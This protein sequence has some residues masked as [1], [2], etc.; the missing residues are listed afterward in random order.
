MIPVRRAILG[1]AIISLSACASAQDAS[2]LDTTSTQG[3]LTTTSAEPEAATTVPTTSPELSPVDEEVSFPAGGLEMKGLLSLPPGQGPHPAVVLVHGSGPLSR[4]SAV[5]GQLN[6]GFGFDLPIFV[7]LADGLRDAGFAVLAYD[8]R[9]CGP[10]NGCAENG[11]PLPSDGLTIDT[12]IDDARAAVQFLRDRSDVDRGSI[13]VVGHSQGAQFV[14]P[15]LVDDPG[16][17]SG[18]MVAG[19]FKPIDETLRD[20][21]DFTVELLAELGIPT[22]QALAS[23]AVAQILELVDAVEAIRSGGDEPAGGVSAAF[24]R[25]WFE[26][27]DRAQDTAAQLSQPLL[28]LNGDLDWNIAS[29]EAEAWGVFLDGIAV[30]HQVAVLPCITHALNCVTESDP[31]LIGVDNIGTEVDPSVI[32][33]LV[34]FLAR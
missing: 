2:D 13:S 11:Y 21:V 34:D 31:A 25:S 22:D 4:D 5:P 12:F 16:I 17:A 32:G 29:S 20:Q 3:Q 28:I 6:L 27:T 14:I 9:S 33:T 15:M 18:V 26:L 19:P 24:W 23:P 30:D 8:K 10:F 7:H 1:W